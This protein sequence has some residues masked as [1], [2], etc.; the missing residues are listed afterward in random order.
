MLLLWYFISQKI[1]ATDNKLLSIGVFVDLAKAFDMVNHKILLF[2][3]LGD[4]TS[5]S[6]L[7]E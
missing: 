6:V 5:Y 2:L 4:I 7:G 3:L 1:V